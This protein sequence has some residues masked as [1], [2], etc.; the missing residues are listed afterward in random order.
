M[1][2]EMTIWDENMPKT[3]D[4]VTK[5]LVDPIPWS[6]AEAHKERLEH[7]TPSILPYID[8]LI[9][10]LSVLE[11]KGALGDALAAEY[12]AGARKNESYLFAHAYTREGVDLLFKHI[13]LPRILELIV[14]LPDHYH[15]LVLENVA[16]RLEKQKN[17]R[18]P[19][20]RILETFINDYRVPLEKASDKIREN[21]ALLLIK[22]GWFSLFRDAMGLFLKKNGK[23]SLEI[24]K[25]LLS[26]PHLEGRNFAREHYN[27]FE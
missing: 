2:I 6:E 19:Y 9:Q 10:T 18:K 11:K 23:L 24:G 8:G 26:C 17:A 20:D 25:A 3:L 27:F 1:D 5:N 22:E 14:L 16:H 15:Q 13:P 12:L 7:L 21:L 4:L